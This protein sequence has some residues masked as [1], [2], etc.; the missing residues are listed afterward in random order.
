METQHE[1]RDFVMTFDTSRKMGTTDRDPDDRLIRPRCPRPSNWR[2]ARFRI[3][4]GSRSTGG[5]FAYA[6]AMELHVP[7]GGSWFDAL[8]RGDTSGVNDLA[9]GDIALADVGPAQLDEAIAALT[10]GDIEYLALHDGGT[11]LQVAGA[12]SGPYEIE[13][14]PGQLSE[15]VR[16]P[17]GIAVDAVR[18]TLQTFLARDPAWA[19]TLP[20]QNAGLDDAKPS[21]GGGVFR[22]LF[23][24][25]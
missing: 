15:Q 7:S 20:W 2:D 8:V 17:D 4:D 23:G 1:R 10:R 3:S 14:N 5:R 13:F 21:P 12:G 16:V 9:S 6:V 11:F 24:R 18:Q 19:G 22:K 25:G